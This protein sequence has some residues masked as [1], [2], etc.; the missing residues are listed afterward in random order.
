MDGVLTARPRLP[1]VLPTLLL[2]STSFLQSAI[3]HDEVEET[4]VRDDWQARDLRYV[5]LCDDGRVVPLGPAALHGLVRFM[6]EV[7]L[8]EEREQR[9]SLLHQLRKAVKVPG[10]APQPAGFL[11]EG[12]F[13][14]MLA[15][16]L[17]TPVQVTRSSDAS[18]NPR[19]DVLPKGQ[20][21]EITFEFNSVRYVDTFQKTPAGTDE[22]SAARARVLLLPRDP[23]EGY[24]DALYVNHAKKEMIAIQ[25]RRF[26]W[27]PHELIVA[28]SDQ[29]AGHWQASHAASRQPELFSG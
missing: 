14:Q 13:L 21:D 17:N 28:H 15:G 24:V 19:R 20:L 12:I 1:S 2:S 3:G 9:D 4:A 11:K 25:V 8:T 26:G 7:A 16:K 29:C 5:R 18:P 22:L 6:L 23:C 10:L 27:T